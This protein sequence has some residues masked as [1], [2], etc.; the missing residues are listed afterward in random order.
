M[1]TIG[2]LLGGV[3]GRLPMTSLEQQRKEER[4]AIQRARALDDLASL[5]GVPSQK[6][7]R[8][9]ALQPE[10]DGACLAAVRSVLAW[11]RSRSEGG[12]LFLAGDPG[13]GKTVAASWAAT[14][15]APAPRRTA[16]RVIGCAARFDYAS[17]YARISTARFGD[18]CERADVL[19]TAKLLVL[20]EAGIEH[21]P[22][23]IS[24]LLIRRIADERVTIITTNMSNAEAQARYCATGTGAARLFSRLAAQ[25]LAGMPWFYWCSDGDRRLGL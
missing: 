23:A 15:Y 9:L 22:N 8:S 25:D 11:D 17:E 6:A 7:I 20:D 16:P 2:E 12:V 3:F 4:D 19:R 10:L 21:D 5:R 18:D 24:E 1:K 14:H 13:C